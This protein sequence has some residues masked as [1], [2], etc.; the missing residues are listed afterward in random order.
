MSE[1]RHHLFVIARDPTVD[2]SAQYL[3][4]RALATRRRNGSVTVVLRDRACACIA[5]REG[6]ALV[7]RLLGS[8]VA[9]HVQPTGDDP[10]VDPADPMPAGLACGRLSDDELV[11]LLLRP[12]TEAY[13]C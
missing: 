8:D 12:G 2:A 1:P 6:D 10:S 5:Q 7:S 4:R 3:L 9:L 13:W 11:D